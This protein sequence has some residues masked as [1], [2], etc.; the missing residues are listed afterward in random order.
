MSLKAAAAAASTDDG[1]AGDFY[2]GSAFIYMQPAEADELE[3]VEDE[4]SDEELVALDTNAYE[5]LAENDDGK[6]L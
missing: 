5:C 1:D 2:A 4:D 6:V 3:E